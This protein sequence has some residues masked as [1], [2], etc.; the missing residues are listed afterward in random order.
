MKE[1]VGECSGEKRYEMNEE[2]IVLSLY[3]RKTDLLNER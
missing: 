1:S 2:I 3:N